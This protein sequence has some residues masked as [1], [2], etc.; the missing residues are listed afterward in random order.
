MAEQVEEEVYS[1]DQAQEGSTD[2]GMAEGG[3]EQQQA[4]PPPPQEEQSGM[5]SA[6][7]EKV[8]AHI[9]KSAYDTRP[10]THAYRHATRPHRKTWI[11]VKHSSH[12]YLSLQPTL[13]R[14]RWHVHHHV[15]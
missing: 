6:Q 1:S 10:A 11:L 15:P 14:S 13:T 2:S 3:E 5:D 8:P 12:P 9:H 7:I 4:Q